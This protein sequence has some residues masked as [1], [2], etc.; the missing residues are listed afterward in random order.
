MLITKFMPMKTIEVNGE[1]YLERY[2]VGQNEN[3][4]QDWLHRFIRSDS[5][6]H[7]H[8]HPWYAVSTILC[9][10]YQ[11]QIKKGD[12]VFTAH[13]DAGEENDIH[14]ERI[15][16][17]IDVMPNTWTHMRVF[18]GREPTWFFIDDEGN[19]KVMETSPVDWWKGCKA[20]VD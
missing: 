15:H 2:Y 19:R 3:G 1:P 9:G 13:R 17:I 7:L 5:E 10:W 11:E 8:S 20:R 18:A 14:P 16:R 4:D 6:R 12:V